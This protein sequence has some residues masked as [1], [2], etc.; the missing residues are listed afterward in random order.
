[1]CPA[2]P[3][4]ARRVR[5]ALA[6]SLFV[7]LAAP[8][9]I[10]Q[11]DHADDVCAPTA[12][13][14]LVARPIA[15]ASGAILDFGVRELRIG[16]G[17]QLDVGSGA[18]E[19]LCGP[20][21]AQAPGEVA[22]KAR[23]PSGTG[24]QDGGSLVLRVRGRCSDDSTRPCLE[25]V[26]C[27]AG[28]CDTSGRL[29]LL[30][31]IEAQGDTPGTLFIEASGDVILGEDIDVDSTNADNDGGERD[32]ISHLGSVFLSGRVEATAGRNAT[33]GIV[34]IRAGRGATIGG[35]VDASGGDFD[36]G[37]LDVT[38]GGNLTVSG[39]VRVDST[40]G[41]GAGGFVGLEAGETL[42]LTSTAAISANGHRSAENFGGDGGT[43]F[44][45][46]GQD[47]SI[48][49]GATLDGDG[50][51]PDAAAGTVDIL[52][53]G[54]VTIAG[55]IA[56]VARGPQGIGGSVTATACEVAIDTGG[57]ITNVG[58]GG[59]NI[60]AT[61]TTLAIASGA[62]ISADART[63]I[64]LLRH[65]IAT[66]L[67]IVL[68]TVTPTARI[69]HVPGLDPCGTG[70]TTTLPTTTTTMPRDCG[71]GSLDVGEE[72]DDGDNLFVRGDSCDSDCNRVACGDP[73]HSGA[74]NASDALIVLRVAVGVESCALCVCNVDSVGTFTSAS[75]A[76]R[77]LNAAVGLPAVLT[78]PTCAD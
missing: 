70:T 76:L 64:N 43:Y 12:N 40:N 41:E 21:N 45:T 22:I 11:V 8:P 73:D 17:G 7:T 63:G 78:C 26:D 23:G 61:A 4:R 46:A 30:G 50:A 6:A 32:V 77:V 68:G 15:V 19:I 44:L 25:H 5:S 65:R 37:E 24:V 28:T 27:L 29:S 67:P 51:R 72:C 39:V 60:L 34:T 48:E 58:E 55:A 66:E 62:V 1:M 20:F 56:M 42:R 57:S 49:A 9:A 18:V 36:G 33:G 31:R 10:A 53:G 52:A 69:E 74:T 35:L 13:P 47:L 38:A 3:G 54:A 14:C 2:T 16:F 75:D 59:E 71:N